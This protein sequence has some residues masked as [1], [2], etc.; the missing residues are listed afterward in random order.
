V[1]AL[2][3]MFALAV[4]AEGA[5]PVVVRRDRYGDPLPPGAIARLG[6]VRFRHG[7]AVNAVA[8]TRDGKAIISAGDDGVIR[9]WAAATGEE[10]RRF[11]VPNVGLTTFALSPTASSW[12]P[13]T[14]T[15]TSASGP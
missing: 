12:P 6:T 14:S 2:L 7:G 4:P 15:T 1:L 3:V 9:L 11:A 10:L 13:S 5:A 8:F